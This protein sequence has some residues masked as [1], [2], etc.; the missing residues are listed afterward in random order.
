MIYTSILLPIKATVNRVEYRI[1]LVVYSND[2]KIF[3]TSKMLLDYL[4][5]GGAAPRRRH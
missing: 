3:S 2:L 1:I 4:R 5:V